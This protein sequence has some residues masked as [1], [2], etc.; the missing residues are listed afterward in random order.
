VYPGDV[1]VGDEDGVVCVP[2]HLADEVAAAAVE[3]ERLE[4]FV[5][6]RIETGA[7]L[8]GTYPPDDRTLAEYRAREAD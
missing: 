6:A 5:L 1:M 3:Q 2:R 4:E 8:R 7:P